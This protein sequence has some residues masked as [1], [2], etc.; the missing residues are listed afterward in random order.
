M[1]SNDLATGVSQ[2]FTQLED[3]ADGA[4]QHEAA[5]GLRQN[6]EAP[7]RAD[8]SA[9]QA[10]QNAFKAAA[11]RKSALVTAQT[12]A[13]SNGRAFLAAARGILVPILG[14]GWNS[15]W[16][17]AG[18]PDGSTSVPSTIAERQALL[19]ALQNYLA[20]HPDYEV[21]TARV[22]VTAARAGELF[23]ALSDARSA[24]NDALTEVGNQKTARDAAL[25]ALRKRGRGV[26]DELGQLLPADSPLWYAFGLNPP[27]A[28][29]TPE[30]PDAPVLTPGQN[31]TLMVDFTDVPRATRYRVFWNAEGAAPETAQSVTVADSDATLS[32][33][34]LNQG[35]QVWGVAANDAGESVA[36]PRVGVALG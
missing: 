10:A 31:G 18:F 21:E 35:L 14:S 12:V 27:A 29:S 7:L 19:L 3:M 22:K 36:S 20:A 11:D 1:A 28:P 32:G 13:D 2:L 4:Q 5:I 23:A 8:L 16:E 6:T 15:S 25:L 17:A 30:A 9:A 34:P 33:L 26:I 24:V